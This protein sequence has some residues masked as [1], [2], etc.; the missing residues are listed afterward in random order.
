MGISYV[1]CTAG[2]MEETLT[3]YRLP[4]TESPVTHNPSPITLIDIVCGRNRVPF[5]DIKLYQTISNYLDN[6]G[7]LLLSTDHLSALDPAWTKQYLH[8]SYYAA[9][10][11]HSGKVQLRYENAPKR[12]FTVLLRPNESQL[13]TDHA[14]GLKAEEATVWATYLDM[15]VPAAVATST[16]LTFGF[17][18]ETTTDFDRL[19]RHAIEWLLQKEE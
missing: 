9:Q 8:T 17:P 16:T 1:S 6:D 15:R 11:T 13:F 2:M 19:Y 3:G 10:A 14:E 18:M 5:N 4:V 7:R 12:P